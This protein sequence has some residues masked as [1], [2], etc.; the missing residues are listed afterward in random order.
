MSTR[1][2]LLEEEEIPK[3][4][5]NIQPD[6][7]KPLPPPLDPKTRAPPAPEVLEAVFAKELVRQE[8]SQER[9]IKIPEEVREIYRIWRPTPLYRALGLEKALKTPAK[10]YY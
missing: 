5:Y 2:I 9:W 1:K 10:I 6:L 7:P 3:Q 8:V 4:W